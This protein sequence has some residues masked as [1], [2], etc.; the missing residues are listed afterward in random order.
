MPSRSRRDPHETQAWPRGARYPRALMGAYRR[1]A[2]NGPLMRLLA[3]E[4]ISSIGDWLY[5]VAILVV[6]YQVTED[7]LVLGIVGAVRLLPYVVLS[8]P[9]GIVADRFDRRRILLVTD[10]ARGL[11]QLVLAALV[12]ADAS[13]WAIVAVAVLAAA[14]GAFFG[15][16]IGAYL[17]IV[18]GD[19]RDLGP[20]NSLWA[21][22]DNLAYFIG[23]AVAG[24]LIAAGGLQVAFLLNA[25]SFGV[26]ALILLGLPSGRPLAHDAASDAATPDGQ[27][28]DP[29]SGRTALLGRIRG[30]IV[31]DLATSFAST[32]LGVLIVLIAVDQLQAGEQAVG[33]LQAATGIGGVVAGFIAGWLVARRLDV[34]LILGGVISAVGLAALAVTSSLGLALVLA[35]IAVGALL[36]MDIV[37]TTIVQRDVPDAQRGRAMGLLQTTGVVAALAGSLVAP[38]L[39][40]LLGLGAVITLVGVLQVV[41]A[42]VAVVILRREGSLDARSDIDPERVALLRGSILI[43]APPSRIESAAR[44]LT[45]VAVT[46]GQVIIRQ[47]DVADRFYLIADGR[48]EVTQIDAA[49][50]TARLRELGPG[51]PF[52]EIGLLTGSPRTATVTAL[53]DGRLLALERETFL[54]LVGPGPELRTG[55]LALYGGLGRPT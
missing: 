50:G 53:T 6:V 32:A 26:C 9:A 33:Y 10:I 51:D 22:L 47:G 5:L 29:A 30:P 36:I 37:V 52:G 54:E 11:L 42:I 24:L 8:V 7:P 1:L 35:G 40:P 34:P 20:A 55:L 13:V 2:R 19:E 43:G 45:E 48:F 38:A 12:M 25:V 46:A 23:P 16:A 39:V 15:P 44:S 21:T 28:G 3:G 49:G 27:A 18:V 41:A 4:T 17:P 31:V 14:F